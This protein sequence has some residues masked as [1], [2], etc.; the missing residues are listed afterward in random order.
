[1]AESVA[2]RAVAG[3]ELIHAYHNFTIP[4]LSRVYTE[5]VAYKYTYDTYAGAGLW[6]K[7]FGIYRTAISNGY[8]GTYPARYQIP[9]PL[10]W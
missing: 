7:A 3:H 10:G 6:N 1:M 9:T 5:R 2:F 8:W 4:N